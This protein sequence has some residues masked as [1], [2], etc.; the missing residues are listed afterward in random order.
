[1]I[2][3]LATFLLCSILPAAEAEYRL[4]AVSDGAFSRPH[5][6]VLSEDGRLLYVADL[7]NDVAKVLTADELETVGE[8]GAGVLRA[9]HDVALNQYGHLVVAD[10]GNDRIIT[11]DLTEDQPEPV[12]TFIRGMSS[13]EG[14]THLPDGR[15]VVANAA[16]GTVGVFDLKENPVYWSK[17]E[18]DTTPYRKPHDVDFD[19]AGRIA[20]ADSGNNRIVV[21][22]ADLTLVRILKGPGYDFNDPKYVAFGD[23]GTLFVAD[24]YNHQIKIF[25]TGYALIDTIGNGEQ[26]S[27]EGQLNKPEGVAAKGDLVWVADTH[28]HRIL[29]FEK[30]R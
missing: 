2:V 20:I 11:F 8:I 6:V 25:D 27:A 26:G 15:Y 30:R 18:S 3:T 21:L 24:E 17:P 13:P 19:G 4:K 28:N 10:S 1:V 14:V 9:P 23:D 16:S 12:Q 22:A 5:D 7:G 29:L